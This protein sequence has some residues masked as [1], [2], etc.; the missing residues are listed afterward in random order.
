MLVDHLANVI[1]KQNDKLI[2]R[3]DLTLQF[4]SV[5]KKNGDWNPLLTQRI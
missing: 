1:L 2:E 4:D 3:L 5:H